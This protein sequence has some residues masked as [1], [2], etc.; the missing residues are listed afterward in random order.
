[1]SHIH[2]GDKEE[3]AQRVLLMMDLKPVVSW[4]RIKYYRRL[5]SATIAFLE[6]EERTSPI[7]TLIGEEYEE[8]KC[9]EATYNK[10][11]HFL[12]GCVFFYLRFRKSAQNNKET[13]VRGKKLSE[14]QVP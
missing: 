8:E 7:L 3:G 13:I 4:S 9:K 14:W 12:N 10:S 1:M 6:N 5:Y 11:N 2:I